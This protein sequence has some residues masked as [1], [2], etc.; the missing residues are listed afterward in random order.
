MPYSKSYRPRSKRTYRSKKTYRSTNKY[1]QRKQIN[2]VA[3]QV[4][5]LRSQS[6][7]LIKLGSAENSLQIQNPVKVIEFTDPALLTRIFD[8]TPAAYQS[9]KSRLYLDK[10]NLDFTIQPGTE[11]SQIDMT[12]FIVSLKKNSARDVLSDT[13]NMSSFTLERDYWD[14]SN[15][16]GVPSGHTLLNLR[17]FNVHYVKRMHTKRITTVQATTTNGTTSG[18]NEY[19]YYPDSGAESQVRKHVKLNLVGKSFYNSSGPW[20]QLTKDTVNPTS[21]LFMLIFNN[22]Y[23]SDG[24]Y[25]VIS[26]TN[27]VTAHEM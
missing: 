13:S 4:R 27:M 18:Q 7:K 6:R 25:P 22:N 2:S 17:R 19:K 24:E 14:W 20:H 3:K 10:V 15:S 23:S 16:L 1:A 12:V 8:D 11:W 5:T 9:L 21:R 26:Y